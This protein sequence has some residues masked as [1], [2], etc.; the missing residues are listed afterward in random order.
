MHTQLCLYK[1]HRNYPTI[2]AKAHHIVVPVVWVFT[3]VAALAQVIGFKRCERP[4]TLQV[5]MLLQP[6]VSLVSQQILKELSVISS[7]LFASAG[8]Y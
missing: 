2:L 8:V 5:D 3:S 6:L 4:C 7:L 1:S